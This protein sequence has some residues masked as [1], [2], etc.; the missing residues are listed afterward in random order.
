MNSGALDTLVV[1]GS[2]KKSV[3][4]KN[5]IPFECVYS[6]DFSRLLTALD[7]WIRTWNW[8]RQSGDRPKMRDRWIV[9]LGMTAAWGLCLWWPLI[10]KKSTMRSKL[11]AHLSHEDVNEERDT[12]M[13]RYP[14][15]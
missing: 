8:M 10:G 13:V 1:V 6:V 11:Q 15:E 5:K 12:E 7:N 9:F 4:A 14:F 2:Y 3:K